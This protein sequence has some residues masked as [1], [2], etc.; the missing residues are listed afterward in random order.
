MPYR[1]KWRSYDKNADQLR[2][3]EEWRRYEEEMLLLKEQNKNLH[4]QL[5][6]RE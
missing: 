4:Q 2:N 6:G 3:E 5:D 1:H